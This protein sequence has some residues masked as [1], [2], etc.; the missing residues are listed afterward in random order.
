MRYDNLKKNQKKTHE[1]KKPGNNNISYN[2]G[3]PV[4]LKD[5]LKLQILLAGIL[6]TILVLITYSGTSANEFVGWDDSEYVVENDLVRNPGESWTKDLFSTVVSSNYHPLTILS[7]RINNNVCSTCPNGISAK[8]FIKTNITLHLFNS[9]LVL[10]LI[11]ILSNRNLLISFLVAAVFA[12]HPMHVESVA[13]ISERKD[14]LYTF[15]FLTGLITYLKFLNEEKRKHLWL[16]LTFLMFVFSC[17]SKPAA[18][19]FPVVLILLNFWNSYNLGEEPI[20]N[21]FK[22]SISRKNLLLLLPFFIVSVFIGIVASRIQNG[23]N[24]FGLL[25]FSKSPGDVVNTIGQFSVIQRFQI[26]SYGFIVY[27]LKFFV[28]INLSPLYPYPSIQELSQGSFAVLL[29]I[30]LVA[31]IIIAFLVILS[32]RKT[33][34]YAFSIG[35]Y[36]VTI[37]LVLQFISVGIAIMS[38]RYSYLPYVGLSLIPA[39]LV[40][41]SSKAKKTILVII[42]VCF[43][44]MLM[45]FSKQQIAVW[46]TTETLWSKV[47]EKHPK[48]TLARRGRGK[49]YYLMSSRAKSYAEKRKLEDKALTDLTEAIRAGTKEALV[50]ESAGVI[51]QTKGDM[52]NALLLLN[53]AISLDPQKGRAYYNRAMVFDKINDKEKAINDYNLALIYSPE[54]ALEVLSN[55]SV[56]FLETGKYNEAKIDLDYLISLDDKNFMYYSNRAYSKVQL[57]DVGGA[58]E[59][60]RAILKLKPND[61]TTMKQL[62]FLIDSQL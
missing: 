28:P 4:L 60:Y 54:M 49:Y 42:S 22:N 33:K 21:A 44:V 45:V 23:E 53:K 61:E 56:L 26:A 47:I 2:S 1:I 30:T 17:L 12:V 3:P 35:F 59:D 40:A 55:R 46:N 34:L 18:V 19:V 37:A 29:N 7:L 25:T 62:K 15:F 57:K 51:Y 10:V 14:V 48:N 13:W 38:E 43:L 16:L 39:T 5:N 58:I 20:K 36:F 31:A 11:F 27:I 9:V 32:L 8:P 6:L 24:V 41:K 50:Y 52:A